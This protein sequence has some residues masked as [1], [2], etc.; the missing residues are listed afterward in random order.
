MGSTNENTSPESIRRW[1]RHQVSLPVRIATGESVSTIDGLATE[2]S[3]GGM[4]LYGGVPLEAG[5]LM[6]VEFP[7]ASPVCVAGIVRNRSGFCFGL[8]FLSVVMSD[9]AAAAGTDSRQH[10]PAATKAMPPRDEN[11]A[12]VAA[13]DK[14]VAL[15]L[16]RHAA[17]L[18][19]KEQ[20]I[21]RVREKALKVRQLRQDIEDLFQGLYRRQTRK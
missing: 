14:L 2:I 10:A 18:Q 20:E 8:E 4:A 21:D 16:Q 13:E 9:P 5:D 1:P 6:A 15:F 3:R 17:Y 7:T 19:N 11:G 12:V